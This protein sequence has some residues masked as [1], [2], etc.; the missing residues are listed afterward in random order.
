MTVA[1]QYFGAVLATV[2][3]DAAIFATYRLRIVTQAMTT[4]FT[5]TMFYYIAKLVRPDAVGGRGH[6]YAFV[7]VGTAIISVLTA[8]LTTSNIVRME[9]VQGN[10]ERIVVSPL[11]PVGGVVAVAAF[12]IL[13]SIASSAL[14]LGL[15]AAFFGV[16]FHAAAIPLALCVG[17]LGALALCSIGFFFTAGLLAY[18]SSM[19]TTWVIAALGLLGGAYFPAKLF[20]GWAPTRWATL[21][22]PPPRSTW[23]RPPRR[24]RAPPSR[25]RRTRRAPAGSG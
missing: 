1:V 22:R 14:M 11:G 10:F 15:A 6:Y 13:Y 7:V 24:F 18:K 4:M 12:P 23:T 2:R 21:P 5:L 20:P 19:G 3:R 25:P 17:V 16:P 8:A 9:L